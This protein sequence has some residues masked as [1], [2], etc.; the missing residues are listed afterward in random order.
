LGWRHRPFD[1]EKCDRRQRHL[2]KMRDLAYKMK[3][4]YTRS[5][6]TSLSIYQNNLLGVLTVIDPVITLSYP[7][8]YKLNFSLSG[9]PGIYW[10]YTGILRV[11]LRVHYFSLLVPGSRP[12]FH[13]FPMDHSNPRNC[14][15]QY[16]KT[17]SETPVRPSGSTKEVLIQHFPDRTIKEITVW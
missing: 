1:S 14:L 12:M 4:R 6:L 16:L 13:N 10:L 3:L 11:V 9:T 8:F 17:S 7:L 15:L 2:R 5:T